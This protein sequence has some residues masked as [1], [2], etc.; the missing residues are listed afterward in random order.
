MPRCF[1]SLRKGLVRLPKD[2]VTG[3]WA[4]LTRRRPR[5]SA[6]TGFP[7]RA[8]ACLILCGLTGAAIWAFFGAAIC[9]T[10]A[11][12]LAADEQVGV[13]AALRYACRKWPA[14]F[15]APLL[16]IGGVLLATIPVLVLGWLMQPTPGCCWAD[17]CGRWCSWPDSSWPC[18]CWARCLA[19]P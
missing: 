10:A 8:V 15:A 19:G 11:V 1:R 14:Y 16:P 4:M 2:P 7:L 5:G 3:S 9:R 17:S 6:S 18:C 12:R 13:G